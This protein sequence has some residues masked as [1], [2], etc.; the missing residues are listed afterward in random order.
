MSVVITL[1]FE[2]P[3]LQLLLLLSSAQAEEEKEDATQ[4]QRRERCSDIEKNKYSIIC[5]VYFRCPITLGLHFFFAYSISEL[6]L[7]YFTTHPNCRVI[8]YVRT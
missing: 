6:I 4:A 2:Q 5:T 3:D 1:H 7:G 8:V